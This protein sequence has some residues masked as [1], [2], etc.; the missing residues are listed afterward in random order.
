MNKK[1]AIKEAVD[2]F[3]A[4]LIAIVDDTTVEA[5]DEATAT[6]TKKKTT[7]KV[8]KKTK[9]KTTRKT[10]VEEPEED[11]DMGFEEDGDEEGEESEYTKEDVIKA[12]KAYV[13]NF[14]DVKKGRAAAKKVLKK[15]E[16][17]SVDEIDEDNYSEVIETLEG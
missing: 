5:D 4:L 14:G 8:A 15:F 11:D 10:K 16:A 9:K 17:A 6:T 1:Q 13:K 12:F 7:K 2:A 3:A